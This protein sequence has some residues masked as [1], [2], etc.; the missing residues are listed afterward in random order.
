M[1]QALAPAYIRKPGDTRRAFG[2]A[3]N[4][5]LFRELNLLRKAHSTVHKVFTGDPA[6]LCCSHRLTRWTLATRALQ[7]FSFIEI[8]IEAGKLL[9]GKH[10]AYFVLGVAG[11]EPMPS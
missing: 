7:T 9:G 5:L 2:F 11:I 8:S 6:I 3:G 1:A 10:E 4:Q